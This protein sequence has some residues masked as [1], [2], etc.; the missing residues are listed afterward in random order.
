MDTSHDEKEITNDWLENAY[1][2]CLE[3]IEKGDL[4][5]ARIIAADTHSR[6]YDSAARVFEWECQKAE[7]SQA[8]IELKK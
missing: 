7:G 3:S 8:L 4:D 6:G 5:T 1:L 2:S